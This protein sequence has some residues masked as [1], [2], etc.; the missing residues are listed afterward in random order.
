MLYMFSAVLNMKK[1]AYYSYPFIISFPDLTLLCW[2]CSWNIFISVAPRPPDPNPNYKIPLHAC[3]L[4]CGSSMVLLCRPSQPP[5][6]MW[7]VINTTK[8]S[9]PNRRIKRSAC[10]C[11]F[12]CWRLHWV[13]YFI[14]VASTRA[15][16]Q[17]SENHKRQTVTSMSL[18]PFDHNY[19]LSRSRSNLPAISDKL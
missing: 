3:L 7:Y 6:A 9:V 1:F 19:S 11:L 12:L 5:P 17:K 16:W 10:I 13:V 4:P 2:C 15:N 8:R 14:C 18:D